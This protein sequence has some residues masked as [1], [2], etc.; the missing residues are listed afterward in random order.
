MLNDYYFFKCLGVISN[1]DYFISYP[2]FYIYMHLF[3]FNLTSVHNETEN[4]LNI[5]ASFFFLMDPWF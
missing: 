3:I 5:Q 1:M 4:S 2:S